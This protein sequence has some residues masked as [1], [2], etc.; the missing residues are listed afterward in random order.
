MAIPGNFLSQAAE[1]MD[2]SY[3]AGWRPRLNII[4]SVGTGGRNGPNCLAM[5]SASAG[6]MQAE[7]IAGYTVVPGQ[8]YQTFADA[9]SST[10][11]ERIGIEWL[12]A[13]YTPV[14]PVT[15]SLTTSAASTS[16]HRVGVAGV[17]PLGAVRARVVLSATTTAA[18][19][20]HFWENVY[21][22]LPIRS[23]GNLLPFNAESG[24][25]VDATA[26][27]AEA[28]T[29]VGRA[30]PP[31]QWSATYYG[32]GGHLITV[33]ATANGTA[34]AVTAAR[35]AVTPGQEYLA[36]VIISP[37]TS[38][39]AC[40][41]ELRF[42]AADG[43]QVQ[44]TRAPLAAPG[45]GLYRQIVSDIAPAGAATCALA[46]GITGATA[47][48]TVRTEGAMVVVMT[49]L[50]TGTVIP[51]AAASFEQG[52]AGWSIVSGPATGARSTPWGTGFSGS[53][54]L[55]ISSATAGTSVLRSPRFPAGQAGGLGWRQ[56]YVTMVTAG[57]W[58]ASRAFHWYDASGASLLVDS[59]PTAGVDSPGW[60]LYSVD[61]TAPAGAA[62]V[63]VEITLTALT[64]NSSVRL[65][66]VSLWQ[67]LPR[68]EVRADDAR[69]AVSL[70]L[71]ELP[72][73]YV[74]SLYRVTP[75]GR[76]TL[77]RGPSGLLDHAP[78]TSDTMRLDDYEAPLGIPVR[79]RV[80]VYDS[81]G[82][83]AN[84]REPD[85]VTLA[86]GDPDLAWVKD[87]GRP[88]R[89]LQVV[90]RAAP[91]W[92]R[93]VDQSA[94][95]VKGRPLPV[96]ISDV[97]D[98]LAGDLAVWTRSDDERAALHLILGSG[99]TLLLQTAPGNGLDDMYV[100][101]G[102]VTES[103]AAT[104]AQD[105]W[106]AWMLP[107]T[108]VDRPTAVGVDG[109]S[110]RTWQDVLA[111]F[112]TWQAVLDAYGTWEDVLLNRKRAGGG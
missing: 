42:Y 100:A 83:L 79:Y 67:A 94:H 10:Q 24:G 102:D 62:A 101:V 82:A 64:A 8:T 46:V 33:T 11:P 13:T 15:W 108:Q 65:D 106:R 3:S 16:W 25:E 54:S 14:G 72:A 66:Q 96:V 86:A 23:P 89:N 93:Q 18:A 19:A 22:G 36:Q 20:T 87:P 41:L 80:L 34:S 105:E 5:K 58:T 99:S 40:W 26:W 90:V 60:W 27:Q 85:P 78:I 74:L 45:T 70:T 92:T 21:L 29:T 59:T 38:A 50:H 112:A 109:T 52:T 43:T 104:N 32:A 84:I 30:V 103:R 47:G 91:E 57:A 12:D 4:L 97:R 95:R 69:A 9:S 53:Y 110:G 39:A 55:S 71:R 2:P 31:V 111:E 56:E 49:P 1:S 63:E 81:T 17:A 98:G 51:Y 77:V 35:P 68:T 61:G 28:N 48:Q 37:P 73:G 107:L 6:E 75:D 88:Q 44:A 76:Q 7:T